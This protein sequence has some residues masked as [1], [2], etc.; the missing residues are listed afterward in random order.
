MKAQWEEEIEK[1]RGE[2]KQA[3][4]VHR[5]PRKGVHFLY[6]TKL[7]HC[8]CVK[9]QREKADILTISI[10]FAVAPHRRGLSGEGG[11]EDVFMIVAARA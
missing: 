3:Y 6:G 5:Q 2:D 8:N 4:A 7:I 9:D 10:A 1:G 11:K